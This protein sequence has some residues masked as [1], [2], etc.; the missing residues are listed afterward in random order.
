[1]ELNRKEPDAYEQVPLWTFSN[2]PNPAVVLDKNRHYDVDDDTWYH[3]VMEQMRAEWLAIGLD[4]P[5]S[6]M[7]FSGFSSQGDGACFDDCTINWALFWP[8]LNGSYWFLSRFKSYLPQPTLYH[9]GR[10]SHELSVVISLDDEYSNAENAMIDD[11]L[12]QRF[13]GQ[14]ASRH[15]GYTA[16]YA[17]WN[18]LAARY[19]PRF[20]HELDELEDEII[21]QLREKM[22]ELYAALEEEYDY[23][24]SN[25][26][27]MERFTDTGFLF[28]ED[29]TIH[30]V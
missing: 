16:D 12:Q 30:Y 11:A 18:D 15:S 25:D 23:L 5:V 21:E 22:Q 10:Y 24:T 28:A 8:Q 1:M 4:V 14:R 29:G 17:L 26:L 13:Q 3:D 19:Q 27:L 7:F 20:C 2:H 9:R 6:Q